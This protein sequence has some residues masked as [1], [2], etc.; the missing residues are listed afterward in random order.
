MSP[1]K[2]L[3]SGIHGCLIQLRNF[4]YQA[5]LF[6][7]VKLSVPVV[8]VG[9]LTMGG[10]GKTPFVDWLLLVLRERKLKVAVVS[11]TY[12]SECTEFSKVDLAAVGNPAKYF[13]DEP[14]L[15]AKKHPEVNFYVGPSKSKSA[16]IIERI[17]RPDLI[18][19]DDGFQHWALERDLD[20]V[21]MDA[22]QPST[23][24][25]LFPMGMGREAISALDRADLIVTTKVNLCGKDFSENVLP[26]IP[27]TKDN[28]KFEIRVQNLYSAIDQGAKLDSKQL[29]HKKVG[30]ISALGRP[31]QFERLVMSLGASVGFHKIHPDHHSYLNA[32][33]Q[34]V[35][36]EMMLQGCDL[37]LTTEKD[38]VKLT[39][40]DS[41]LLKNIW[42]VDLSYSLV[43]PAS[44]E[45][46]I[47]E[48]ISKV[49]GHT[50]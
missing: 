10:T 25:A 45:K 15:L 3:L 28:L 39:H 35:Q 19:V 9:N 5:H 36:N 23:D 16:K 4:L 11:R 20:I 26:L 32:D 6:R 30:L 41:A 34:D 42:V 37:I 1:L 2:S 8:S 33:L 18:I 7:K 44:G 38:A 48:Q 17:E 24:Y 40:L 27:D 29:A 31:V 50:H 21:V 47:N 49:L 22:T 43:D 46:I 12:K 13:G 14:V